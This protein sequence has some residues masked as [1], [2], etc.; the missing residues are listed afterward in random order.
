MKKLKPILIIVVAVVAALVISRWINDD[1]GV[2]S[3]KPTVPTQV[4]TNR[5]ADYYRQLTENQKRIYDAL[6]PAVM[7]GDSTVS[8]DGIDFSTVRNDMTM[9]GE[10]FE[11]DHP[12]LFWFRQFRKAAKYS[13]R[14]EFT[15][16]YYSYKTSFFDTGDKYDE[17]MAA[18]NA[19]ADQARDHS[20]D[21][22]EQAVY[23]HDHIIKNAYYDKEALADY[24]NT[25]HDPASEYI[26]SAYG[27]LVRGQTV[28][29]GYAKAY[30]LVMEALGA[31]C[32]YA[33]GYANG[34]RH[35]WNLLY[36]NDEHYFVDI[37]WDDYDLDKE[38]PSY[39]YAFITEEA[40]SR[41]HELE[42]LFD[43]PLCD[44]ETYQYYRYHGY[45][46]DTYDFDSVSQILSPQADNDAAYI[47]FG[48]AM[49]FNNAR[50]ELFK[51]GKIYKIP[52][53]SGKKLKFI[54]NTK[55]NAF[56]IYPQ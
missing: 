43:M 24:E 52:G 7:D 35:A 12:E 1:S 30:Q 47:Q 16:M 14:V 11:N 55:H 41:T 4:Q 22:Y 39:N 46:A 44:D 21:L 36:L 10:A 53:Y 15:I 3:S 38:I 42:K 17:L 50:Q 45:Y 26:F 33:C 28:C 48:S 23:V 40:L 29:A 54:S 5:S 6:L 8:V 37:T 2:S 27:C 32:S 25:I 20:P 49:D 34:G 51:S 56:M 19:L 9:V 18:V 31:Q 13:D